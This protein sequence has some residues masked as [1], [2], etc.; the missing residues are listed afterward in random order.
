[1]TGRRYAKQPAD[2]DETRDC[3]DPWF[4]ALLDAER[5]LFPCCWHPP[6]GRLGIGQPIEELLEGEA[7]RELRRQILEGDL[8]GACV[9]CP[10]RPLT[11]TDSFSARLRAELAE[12]YAAADTAT[13]GART[14]TA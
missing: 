2:R 13:G 12:R 5:N 11:D 3:L 7:M 1:M 10:S 8:A 6:I 9:T 4:F 14:T